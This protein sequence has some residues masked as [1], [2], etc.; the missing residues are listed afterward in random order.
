MV[1]YFSLVSAVSG[2]LILV[3]LWL[4][5]QRLT[6]IEAQVEEVKSLVNEVGSMIGEWIDGQNKE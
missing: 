3:G 5:W 1:F 2:V 4:V 6:R